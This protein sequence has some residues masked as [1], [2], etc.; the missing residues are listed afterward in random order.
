MCDKATKSRGYVQILTPVNRDIS[1]SFSSDAGK[2]KVTE[3]VQRK[4][5]LQFHCSADYKYINIS[6]CIVLNLYLIQ[7]IVLILLKT[8]FSRELKDF[9]GFYNSYITC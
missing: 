4:Q 9:L 6:F 5:S 1:M 3:V 8:I 7:E 2:I